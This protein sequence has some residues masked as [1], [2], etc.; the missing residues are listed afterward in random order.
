[1]LISMISGKIA[2]PLASDRWPD[3]YIAT[4]NPTTPTMRPIGNTIPQM[5][6][7]GGTGAAIGGST[8]ILPPP[9]SGG[10]TRGGGTKGR[11]VTS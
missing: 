8:A 3:T 6:R 4:M 5:L 10:G 7:G 1:M 9:A 2:N 11:V